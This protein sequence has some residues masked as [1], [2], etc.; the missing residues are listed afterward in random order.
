MNSLAAKYQERVLYNKEIQT[1]STETETSRAE[2]D[3]LRQRALR[4]REREVDAERAARERELEQESVQLDKEIEAVMHGRLIP[5]NYLRCLCIYFIYRA[6]RGRKDQH[7]CC[8][9]IS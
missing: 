2:E 8:T 1:T 6:H 3:E 5:A 7:F 9:R 4:E